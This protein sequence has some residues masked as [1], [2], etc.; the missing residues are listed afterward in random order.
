MRTAEEKRLLKSRKREKNGGVVCIY[1]H[2]T[3]TVLQ[4]QVKEQARHR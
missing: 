1:G 2:F 3:S 4:S